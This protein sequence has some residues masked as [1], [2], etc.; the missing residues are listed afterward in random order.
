M[1]R[2]ST[3]LKNC[4]L[5]TNSLECGLTPDML[6]AGILYT[7]NV[8]DMIDEKLLENESP[9]LSGL[10]EYAN[11][12]TIIGNLLNIGIVKSSGNLFERAGPH[13][14]QDLRATEHN[15]HKQHIE[16]KVAMEKNQPKGHLPKDGYYLTCRYVLGD[17]EG[18]YSRGQRGDV[19]WI[20]ELRFGH[21]ERRHFNVSNTE[22]DSG[23]TAVVNSDGMESLSLLYFDKS[24]CPYAPRSQ[25]L[26]DVQKSS[27][28]SNFDQMLK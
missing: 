15:P 2:E 21:L 20:W 11:L 28:W 22:G 14:Y 1:T 19:V 23:K 10:V 27:Q 5:T 3:S 17:K 16:I 9:W 12:S 4:F 13:K 24:R 7:Y 26:K 25:Y 18:N 6:Y 8:L